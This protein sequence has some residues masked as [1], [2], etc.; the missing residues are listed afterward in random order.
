M[1]PFVPAL[2]LTLSGF[3]K[4]DQN[5]KDDQDVPLVLLAPNASIEWSNDL[6][7]VLLG[8]SVPF[9]LYAKKSTIESI[10]GT[11]PSP[12]GIQPWTAAIGVSVSPF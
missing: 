7:A 3:L 10:P 6:V 2:G 11:Q 9:G 5:A 8:V 12:T 4:P 1:G